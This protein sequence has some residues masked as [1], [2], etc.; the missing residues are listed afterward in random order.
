MRDKLGILFSGLCIAH[1][2]LMPIVMI[3]LSGNA[4][5]S[6]LESEWVHSLL[7]VPIFIVMMISLPS[8]WL[9]TRNPWI[10]VFAI[11]GAVLLLVSRATH[12]MSEVL[13]TLFGSS[14][15][16]AAHLV[17]FKL[18]RFVRSPS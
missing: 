6:V 4:L 17:S 7:L 8:S 10:L 3:L 1:C 14:S 13:L 2:L 9:K 5:L 15:L 12:G 11:L 16:I 18:R